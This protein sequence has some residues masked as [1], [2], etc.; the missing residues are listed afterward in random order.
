MT[1]FNSYHVTITPYHVICSMQ[2]EIK[3]ALRAEC[4]MTSVLKDECESIV[5]QYFPMIWS[6]VSS[7][8]VS[9]CGF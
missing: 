6:L 8:V 3:A 1:I 7:Y 9:G 2:T 4:N 5:D